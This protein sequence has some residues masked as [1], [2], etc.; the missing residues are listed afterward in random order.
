MS[1]A[2]R[3]AARARARAAASFDEAAV[4][5]YTLPDPLVCADG[6]R[7]DT[8]AQWPRRRAE[9]LDL[10][11]RCVF[12]R[13]P[14]FRKSVAFSAAAEGL[15]LD[16]LVRWRLLRG[17]FAAQG[18]GAP[19]LE[20]LLLLPAAA[21]GPVP[22]FAVLN[23][24]GNHSLHADPALPLSSHWCRDHPG[25]EVRRGGDA[26][27]WP[28]DAIVRRGFG[29]ATMYNGDV[30]PDVDDGFR[31]AV[32]RLFYA[33]GQ[34][35]PAADEWGAVGAW[36]W[37]LS[38]VRD[39]LEGIPEVD[40]LRVAALGHSRLGKAALW[41]GAQDERFAMVIANASGCCGAALSRRRFGERPALLNARFP[42]WLCAAF[43]QWDEREPELP[44]DQHL[45]LA[46]I[47][48]RPLYIASAAED[49][50][51]DP[52]G[53][54]LAAVAAD[55][56]YRLLGAGGLAV[57]EF[58]AVDQPLHGT[59]GYHCRSGGH[60]LTGYDWERFLDFAVEHGWGG[61][62]GERE[63]SALMSRRRQT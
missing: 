63:P 30:C 50:W 42:H 10:F 1:S 18:R 27:R 46:L 4:P 41:A 19:E 56:V 39:C 9:I 7:V 59:I 26:A 28:L 44:V 53:E 43:R 55:P 12:G 52:R 38:R 17:T 29:V 21:A 20:I 57:T 2:E 61:K 32:H 3:D 23:H 33:P 48:P 16:G 49:L 35:R 58:P 24:A 34:T 6:A 36:A 8:A 51:A 25:E 54:F 31:Y 40:A 11:A 15:A 45:L 14:Q 22:V 5:A 37:G 13:T 47:A 62:S 60:D